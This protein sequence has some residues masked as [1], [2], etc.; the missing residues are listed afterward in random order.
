MPT[1]MVPFCGAGESVMGEFLH[2]VICEAS[3]AAAAIDESAT[4][5]DFFM[6]LKMLVVPCVDTY[7]I[8]NCHI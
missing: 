3:S 6:F 4:F 7:S 8:P 5:T 1:V 2:A